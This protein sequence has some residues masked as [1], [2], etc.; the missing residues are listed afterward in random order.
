MLKRL[1]DLSPQQAREWIR[2][3]RDAIEGKLQ[4]GTV[5]IHDVPDI[6]RDASM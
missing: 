5:L 6:I 1:N 4:S 3:R 2:Y